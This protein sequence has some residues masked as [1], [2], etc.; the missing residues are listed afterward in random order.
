M[1]ISSSLACSIFSHPDASREASKTY[2]NDEEK[3]TSA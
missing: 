2:S 1:V 3:Y